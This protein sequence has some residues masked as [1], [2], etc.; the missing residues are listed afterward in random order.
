MT[1]ALL[2][3]AQK[4]FDFFRLRGIPQNATNFSQHFRIIEKANPMPSRQVVKIRRWH[5]QSL[6]AKRTA[7]AQCRHY[8]G[9]CQL[10]VK[11]RAANVH[12]SES[13][14]VPAPVAR[15]RTLGGDPHHRKVGGA[16]ADVSHE[17]DLLGVDALLIVEGGRDRLELEGNA[18]KT[19]GPSSR[20]ELALRRGIRLGVVVDKER[21]PAEHHA[22]RQP[23]EVL[24]GRST[25]KPEKRSDNLAESIA[26]LL[27]LR[28][29]LKKLGAE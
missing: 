25:Q 26:L 23:T 15:S 11:I 18:L 7:Q 10:F 1:L 5:I 24:A 3:H 19:G 16:A 29:L 22:R 27:D 13:E 12:A 4:P 8:G 28:C 20:L 9:Y 17:R 21:R 14:N 2:E 6:A